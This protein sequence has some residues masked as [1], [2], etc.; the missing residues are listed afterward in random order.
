M[1]KVITYKQEGPKGIFSQIK[2][3]NGDRVLISIA[4]GEIKIF[5][6]KFFGL[7]PTSTIWQ[8]PSLH[9]FFDLTQ[10]NGY[11]DMPLDVLVNKVKNFDSIVQMQTELNNFITNL[12]L[13]KK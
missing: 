12:N 10:K 11:D 8:Y 6:L 2:L 9:E 13:D 4:K 7:V 5:K 3:N 1:G